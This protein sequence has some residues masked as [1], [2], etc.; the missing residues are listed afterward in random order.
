MP[1]FIRP[2]ITHLASAMASET[3][4][5]QLK[6]C[7]SVRCPS[8]HRRLPHPPP[9]PPACP[10]SPL[11]SSVPLPLGDLRVSWISISCTPGRT[12]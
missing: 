7:T 11:V 6:A 9:L 3:A 5:T 10:P 4:A 1:L 2:S 8:C 12:G